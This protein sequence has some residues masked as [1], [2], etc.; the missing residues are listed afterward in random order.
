[1][2]LST[3]VVA[4][5]WVALAAG[6]GSSGKEAAGTVTVS[7][8]GVTPAATVVGRRGDAKACRADGE[9]VADDALQFLAHSGARAAYPADLDYVMLREVLADFQARGCEPK[10]MGDPL[11]KRLTPRQRSAFAAGLPERMSAVVREALAAG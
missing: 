6:C 9:T 8:Y 7:G 4:L 1:M 2:R 11:R 10:A 5:A 3:G